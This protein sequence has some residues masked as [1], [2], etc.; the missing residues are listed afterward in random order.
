MSFARLNSMSA[1]KE[2]FM[3]QLEQ[4]KEDILASKNEKLPVSCKANDT[5]KKNNG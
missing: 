1:D 5:L 4:V 3:L 2:S